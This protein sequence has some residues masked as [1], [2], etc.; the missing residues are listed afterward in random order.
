MNLTEVL[1][2]VRL[3]T[4]TSWKYFSSQCWRKAQQK[5]SLRPIFF[6]LK[7]HELDFCAVGKSPYEKPHHQQ[8]DLE[9]GAR[10]IDCE[11]KNKRQQA[12]F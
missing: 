4:E 10:E 8:Q 9:V 1:S 3:P 6:N 5:Q 12:K 7:L 2:Y 11:R